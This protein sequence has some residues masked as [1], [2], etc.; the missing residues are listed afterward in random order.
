MTKEVN[1]TAVQEASIRAAVAQAGVANLAVATAVGADLGKSARSVIAKM[2]RMGI[3][4][5]RKARV[6]KAGGEIVRKSELVARIATLAGV[7]ATAIASLE[8]ASKA[9]LEVLAQALTA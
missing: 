1:Y 8:G 9:E 3:T 5:E 7:Q 6:T 2:V 4:Y